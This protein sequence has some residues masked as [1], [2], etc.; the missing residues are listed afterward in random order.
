MIGLCMCNREFVKQARERGM[1][2]GHIFLLNRWERVFPYYCESLS[3]LLSFSQHVWAPCDLHVRHSF[4]FRH[5]ICCHRHNR[6][7]SPGA[8]RDEVWHQSYSEQPATIITCM[9]H[10]WTLGLQAMFSGTSNI[11]DHLHGPAYHC[12]VL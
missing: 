11:S 9:L 1:D 7:P 10:C 4:L 6:G 2:D 3:S 8:Q 5:K 12:T